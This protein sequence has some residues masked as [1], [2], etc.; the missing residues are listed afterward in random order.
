MR[1]YRFRDEWVVEAAPARV[2]ELISQAS[3]YPRWWPIYQGATFV[4]DTG[5]VGSVVRLKFRV[6]L[7][8]TLSILTTTTRSEPPRLAEGTVTGELEG[9]WRWALEP[10]GQGTRVVF[11]EA[12]GTR[13]WVL[14]LLAPIAYKL[15][16]LNHRIAARRGAEGMRAY[17]AR[18]P[19]RTTERQISA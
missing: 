9:T 6:L 5:G 8:Y 2:W 15:F 10:Q 19:D 13:K 4:K 7:P 11:E 14:N 12:V 3:S 1:T 18:D 17:L 16:E